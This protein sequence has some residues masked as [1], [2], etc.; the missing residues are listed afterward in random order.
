MSTSR[1]LSHTPH[2]VTVRY[3]GRRLFRPLTCHRVISSRQSAG[4]IPANERCSSMRRLECRKIRT[5]NF[6]RGSRRSRPAVRTERRHGGRRTAKGAADVRMC[7]S[8]T[9]ISPLCCRDRRVSCP[10]SSSGRHAAVPPIFPDHGALTRL[11][12]G[13]FEQFRATRQPRPLRL[14]PRQAANHHHA[15]GPDREIGPVDGR[16]P[17]N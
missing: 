15:A 6:C 9:V 5:E 3:G 17:R 4:H 13:N 1:I 14:Y 10:D 11:F 12:H 16:S 2:R 8:L 7:L